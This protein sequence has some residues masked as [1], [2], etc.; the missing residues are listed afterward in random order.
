MP[1]QM[2]VEDSKGQSISLSDNLRFKTAASSTI[3]KDVIKRY[4][5]L[6]SSSRQWKCS[7]SQVVEINT[8]V[9]VLKIESEAVNIDTNYDYELIMSTETKD[10]TIV[11][12]SPFGAM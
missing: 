12:N 1:K 5:T 6:I 9:I 8:I 10:A 3:L 7:L 4:K 2:L 11:A